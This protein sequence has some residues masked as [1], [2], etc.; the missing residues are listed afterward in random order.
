MEY[1]HIDVWTPNMTTFRVKLVDFGSDG[2][3]G[4][5]DTEHEVVFDPQVQNNWVS[6]QIPLADF[7]NLASTTHLAQLILSGLP[8]GNGVLYIDNVYFSKTPTGLNSLKEYNLELFPNPALV[9]N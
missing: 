1:F 7:T 5:D 3:F 8:A 2:V 6:Y 9:L 4:N